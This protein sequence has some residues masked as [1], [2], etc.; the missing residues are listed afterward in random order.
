M[1]GGGGTVAWSWRDRGGRA[2]DRNVGGNGAPGDCGGPKRAA[3]AGGSGAPSG[4]GASPISEREPG[5]R[6]ALLVLLEAATRGDPES[7][8]LWTSRSV[9][10]LTAALRSQGFEVHE[11]TVRRTA[12]VGVQLAGQSQDA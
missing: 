6:E 9:Q 8:L 11:S 10:N 7:P 5:L 3:G 2:G 12:G 1:G 4:G